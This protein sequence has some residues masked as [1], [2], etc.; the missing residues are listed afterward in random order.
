MPSSSNKNFI[1]GLL[2]TFVI[3]IFS[4]FLTKLPI[5]D[6]IGALTIAILIALLYRHFKGY[7]ELY[8]PGITFS[9]KYL[10]RFA[11]ILY[12]L[13]LNIT[14]ILEQGSRLLLVDI[15]VVVFSIFMMLL[16]SRYLRG[17]TN[18][19]LLLGVGTGVC[20]AA[21]I[22]AVAPIFKSRE[23]DTA[24]SIGI[25]ALIGT[26]FSLI[27]TAIDAIFHISPQIYGAWSG[28]SLHE[29]AH[30]VLAGGFGGS[31]ALKIALLG[32]LGRVFL[33]I[34][35][36]IILILVMRW[37]TKDT[38]SQSR[39]SIPYFLIGFVIMAIV[40][41][42]ISIPAV[43]LNILNIVATI[44]LLM[45]MVALGLNVAFKDIKQ[46]ALKPLLTIVITSIVLS[47]ITFIIINWLY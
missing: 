2:F 35:L 20:G 7:P 3:A 13:K 45:A 18:I 15:G 46:R 34:P 16:V 28:V 26:I 5:F 29:I 14:D 12:G 11:I 1:I 31:E 8:R 17:D 42:Y 32:K 10:L 40:N 25:I 33:L 21:A 22:A 4:F 41:T 36:T 38:T 9:S 6:K 19:A 37:K 47:V 39:I 44:C 24:I 43:I 27:Y 23:K 30:V